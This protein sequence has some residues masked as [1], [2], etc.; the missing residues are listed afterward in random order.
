FQNESQYKNF[1]RERIFRF[2]IRKSN[3]SRIIKDMIAQQKQKERDTL[4]LVHKGKQLLEESKTC[5]E[6]GINDNDFIILMIFVKKPEGQQPQQ[7]QNQQ[8]PQQA[9]QK[10]EVPPQK[11]PQ[12]QQ[13][14]TQPPTQ[15]SDMVM[16]AELE[17]KIADIESM[18]FERSKVIQALKAA[19]NN[20]ERAVEYLL[21][22]HIPS[23]PAFEQPPQQPQQPQQGGVLGEEGV[24]NLG[25]LEELQQ[26]AQNPQFQQI[27]MA[28]RQNPALLQPIMLQLAQS[29]P[30]LATLLQQNPQAFL[31][32]LMQAT[33]GEQCIFFDNV[34]LIFFFFVEVSRNAIQVTPEEKADI[35]EIVSLGFDKNDALEAY[36]SCD[37][38]KELA[39]NYLFD[40][41]DSGTLLSSHI[42]KEEYE[43]AQQQSLQNQNQNQNQST[44]QNQNSNNQNQNNQ[45]KK[46]DEDD[47]NIFN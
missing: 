32:L 33:G 6:L 2:V 26:L 1:K 4:K 27:A 39:I 46:D 36:I 18:G 7:E 41:K 38:N 8:Q 12:Q 20:P 22:G 24:G 25:G 5:G 44:N 10:P 14:Q 35:D 30:Q 34:I 15:A 45:N 23:R 21:S 17:A 37:K 47:D 16:G 28:I 43:S 40:A 9:Q 13:P 31:Q 3:N 11:P 29:N 42:E 19:Y